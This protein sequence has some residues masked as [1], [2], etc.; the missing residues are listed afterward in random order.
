MKS[1]TKSNVAVE[2]FESVKPIP[3]R[4]LWVIT[5]SWSIVIVSCLIALEIYAN[6]PGEAG[7]A[8]PNWPAETSIAR[9]SGRPVMILFM[10]PQCP[11]SRASL[12]ELGRLLANAEGLADVHVLFVTPTG[13]DE[14]W[15]RTDLWD[16]A[17]SLPGVR[18]MADLNGQEAR[19]FDAVTSGT[20]KLYDG[21]GKLVFSG[22]ITSARGHAGANAGRDN[23]FSWLRHGQ[24]HQN[25]T[26]VFGC[27][28]FD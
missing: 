1:E 21:K 22:G 12:E 8:I 15:E 16:T 5:G 24:L 9:T 25:S 18:V 14:G 13:M 6:T 10:H 26:L 4:R 20:L 17:Q 19:R 2:R 23:V 7:T 3:P 11:C 28:L 27:P